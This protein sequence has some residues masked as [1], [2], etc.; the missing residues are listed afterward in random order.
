MFIWIMPK[1]RKSH[2]SD[3]KGLR[4]RLSFKIKLASKFAEG[5]SPPLTHHSEEKMRTPIMRKSMRRP[6]SL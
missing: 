2:I 6:S 3:K 5:E 4:G 1:C